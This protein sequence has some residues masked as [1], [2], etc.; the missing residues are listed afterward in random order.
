CIF[1]QNKENKDFFLKNVF[2][3]KNYKVI[4]G[5]GVNIEEFYPLEYPS[6]ELTEFIFISR[7]MKEKGIDQFLK[8]AKFIVKKYPNTRFH[9]LGFCEEDYESKLEEMESKGIIK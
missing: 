8:A 6:E 9:V 7:I 3:P 2:V 5:S 1:F 4:P